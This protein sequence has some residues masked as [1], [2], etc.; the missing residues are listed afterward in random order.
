[1]KPLLATVSPV[2]R[3][4]RVGGVLLLVSSLLNAAEPVRPPAEPDAAWIALVQS[5]RAALQSGRNLHESGWQV[6]GP[7]KAASL[8]ESF[9]PEQETDLER[10][11]GRRK[12]WQAKSLP[13][14]IV[15]YLKVKEKG[16]LYLYRT[17]TAKA[18]ET[19]Q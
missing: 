18:A 11:S 9:F 8:A 6:A 15:N 14:G 19:V 2:A 5:Q 7:F 10:R 16:T 1:M 17:L 3:L 12:A 4:A 13:N